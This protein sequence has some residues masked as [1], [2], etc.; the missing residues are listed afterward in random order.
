MEQGRTMAKF[1]SS[2]I[3][4]NIFDECSV[5][6]SGCAVP[7]CAFRRVEFTFNLAPLCECGDRRKVICY[8]I[9]VDADGDPGKLLI[10]I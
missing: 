10:I 3:Y 4:I 1:L 5:L 2:V 9:S 6:R 7:W 8:R